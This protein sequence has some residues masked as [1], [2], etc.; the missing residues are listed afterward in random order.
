MGGKLFRPS[1]AQVRHHRRQQQRDAPDREPQ[2]DTGR[3]MSSNESAPSLHRR[4][5]QRLL[6]VRPIRLP[7]M[8]EE[9]HHDESTVNDSRPQ[10]PDADRP[11]LADGYQ[12][13]AMM[14]DPP[15]A[16][17]PGDLARQCGVDPDHIGVIW[18]H[19]DGRT[20][21]IDVVTEHGLTAR[22]AL[23]DWGP[24]QLEKRDPKQKRPGLRAHL[25]WSHPRLYLTSFEK[26]LARLGVE[27][28]GRIEVG[29]AS[30]VIHGSEA[31]CQALQPLIEG[32]RLNGY[33]IRTDYY[34]PKLDD[35][36]SRSPRRK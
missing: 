6:F 24:V 14:F 28:H 7:R 16:V 33:L 15:R 36:Q 1:P 22:R 29:N 35:K 5:A 8:P 19:Q 31:E 32:Q 23:E 26:A 21:S 11:A 4:G 34:T 13:L 9:H 20:A 3:T 18:I 2:A 10:G 30:S 27:K 12:R 25:S 17:T